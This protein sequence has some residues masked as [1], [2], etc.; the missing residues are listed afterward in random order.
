MGTDHTAGPCWVSQ[1]VSQTSPLQIGRFHETSQL[2]H[3]TQLS[4]KHNINFF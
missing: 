4:A 1:L 3:S 2:S